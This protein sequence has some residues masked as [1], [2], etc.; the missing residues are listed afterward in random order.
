MK[1]SFQDINPLTVS[2]SINPASQEL[3]GFF[4]D[5]LNRGLSLRIKVTGKSMT[6]FLKG[7][8]IIT[9]KKAALASLRKGDLLF[10]RNP[11]GHPVLHRIVRKEFI[12]DGKPVFQTKG[13]A[14]RECDGVVTAEEIMGRVCKIED[15]KIL[16]GIRGVDMESFL[17]K[18]INYVL[19]VISLLESGVYYRCL[20]PV[21]GRLKSL[22]RNKPAII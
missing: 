14:L 16:P 19:A 1:N 5:I 3:A 20:N 8:E 10:F 2:E 18:R 17:W 22:I 7:G 13:D 6:P 15:I 21:M 12:A 4:E 11:D 9:I